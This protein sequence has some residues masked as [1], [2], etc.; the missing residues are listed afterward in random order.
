MCI[1]DSLQDADECVLIQRIERN[2]GRQTTDQLGDQTELHQIMR[3]DLGQQTIGLLVFLSLYLRT[4]A[5][6]V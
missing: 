3:L 4:K 1:R 6:C 2:D 5:R